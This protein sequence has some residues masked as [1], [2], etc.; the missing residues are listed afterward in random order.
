MDHKEFRRAVLAGY[1]RRVGEQQT[2]DLMLEATLDALGATELDADVALVLAHVAH[3]RAALA[4]LQARLIDAPGMM[5]PA[6]QLL[7]DPAAYRLWILAPP[8]DVAR[9]IC[10]QSEAIS[11]THG[12]CR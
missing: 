3:Q 5:H 10:N 8:G 6:L 11:L 9:N 7:T 2:G 4:A 1:I 12:E